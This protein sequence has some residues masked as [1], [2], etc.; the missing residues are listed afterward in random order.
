MGNGSHEPLYT[1]LGSS[2]NNCNG[3]LVNSK[4]YDRT[5]VVM[6]AC[7]WACTFRPHSAFVFDTVT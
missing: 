5:V 4:A 3:N 2:I 7:I 1:S 6:Y